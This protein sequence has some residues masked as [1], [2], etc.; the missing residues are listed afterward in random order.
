MARLIRNND[1]V[2]ID[3]NLLKYL[4][5][6]EII[7][8]IP[9]YS[10]YF[11]T[12]FGRVF[13]AKKKI[14]YDTLKGDKY[15]AILWKELKPRVVNGYL[16]INITNDYNQRKTEYIHY[17]VYI[18][19]NNYLDKSVLKIVH[20]DKNK[21]NNNLS[22]LDITWRKKEDYQAHKVYVYREKMKQILSK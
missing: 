11:A 21:L 2:Q 8:P 7:K 10:N 6:G 1:R 22:N 3:N 16:A 9:Q 4:R 12:S 20:R 13:S 19:F 17:L 14:E 18:A 15:Q 5:Y